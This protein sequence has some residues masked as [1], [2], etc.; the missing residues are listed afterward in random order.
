MKLEKFL[1]VTVCA[2]LTAFSLA[3]CSDDNDVQTSFKYECY[4]DSVGTLTIEDI[5]NVELATTS[6]V[7]LSNP[8]VV[9]AR[10]DKN[11]TRKHFLDLKRTGRVEVMVNDGGVMYSISLVVKTVFINWEY[12]W[13]VD[14]ANETVICNPAIKQ[15]IID[16]FHANSIMPIMKKEDILAVYYNLNRYRVSSDKTLRTTYDRDNDEYVFEEWYNPDGE[17]RFKFSVTDQGDK[18]NKM[19]AE[20]KCD[21]TEYYQNKY[22]KDMVRQVTF[23]YKIHRDHFDC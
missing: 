23:V 16:D 22:G 15:E 19:R 7:A 1:A 5:I 2:M 12:H 4:M 3:G 6:V 9:E 11:N 20:L 18:H 14:E 17:Q 21:M 13:E 8:D 10:F